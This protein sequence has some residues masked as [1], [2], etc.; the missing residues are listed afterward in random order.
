[1][2]SVNVHAET[3]LN[4]WGV[5][6]LLTVPLL[7]MAGMVLGISALRDIRRAGGQ[8]AGALPAA[9]AACLLPALLIC[10]LSAVAMEMLG[11][12][13][14]RPGTNVSR[15]VAAGWLMGLLASV[16]LLQQVYRWATPWRRREHMT[17]LASV[18]MALTAFGM[19][20]LLFLTGVRLPG[21]VE[22]AVPAVCL[23][24][25]LVCGILSRREQAGQ[26]S[27]ITSGG[28]LMILLLMTA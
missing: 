8:L 12:E 5:T 17:A 26:L 21:V 11:Q 7:L 10:C 4:L 3:Y 19:T 6:L 23:L 1:M 15:W 22:I 25:G 14:K 28:G 27:A 24:G 20:G 2:A 13:L 16:L 18:A 9:F